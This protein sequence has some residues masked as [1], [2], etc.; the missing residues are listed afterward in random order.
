VLT[1]VVDLAHLDTWDRIHR[2]FDRGAAVL[3]LCWPRPLWER[4]S[5]GRGPARAVAA[6]KPRAGLDTEHKIITVHELGEL[7]VGR[8]FP[9]SLVPPPGFPS[10]R[11]WRE[12]SR[13]AVQHLRVWQPRPCCVPGALLSVGVSQCWVSKQ[14]PARWG[15][16]RPSSPPPV[17]ASSH[18][19]TKQWPMRALDEMAGKKVAGTFCGPRRSSSWAICFLHPFSRALAHAG[20]ESARA[21]P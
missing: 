7:P 3:K 17:H 15:A 2:Y 14:A 4:T 13:H 19:A 18:H 6:G 21:V 9:N 16:H 5:T 12:A 8:G 10:V 20:S 1:A 11:S